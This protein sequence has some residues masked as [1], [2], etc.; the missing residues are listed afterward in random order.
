[1]LPSN[2]DRGKKELQKETS[3]SLENQ[4]ADTRMTVKPMS[5]SS[6]EDVNITSLLTVSY[7]TLK[8]HVFPK[9]K[10]AH[11]YKLFMELHNSSKHLPTLCDFYN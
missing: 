2:M 9:Q 11:E 10:P 7:D 1:M 8:V 5:G 3:I 4:D 6:C